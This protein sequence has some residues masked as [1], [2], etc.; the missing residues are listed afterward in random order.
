ME[1][2]RSNGDNFLVDLYKT[3]VTN[4]DPRTEQW[5]FVASPLPALA[6]MFGYFAVVW[7]GPKL[8][9][10]RKA[11]DLGHFLTVF[12]FGLVAL[13]FYITKEFLMSAILSGHWLTCQPIDYSDDPLAIRMASACW[14]YYISKYIE[15]ADTVFFILRKKGN[16]ITFL[17]VFHH[18]TMIFNWWMCVKY[19][20]GGCTV[21][22]AV[23]NSIVHVIMYTYYGLSALGPA[24]QPY[25]WWKKYVTKIQLTQFVIIL[26]HCIYVGTHCHFHLKG[27]VFLAIFYAVCM[28]TLF[29][30]Y[31]YQEYV[32]RSRLKAE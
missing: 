25:L 29:T 28:I 15:T 31:Y 22:H 17:H 16:Q 2:N 4:A 14:F 20:A 3:A 1:Q 32:R 10:N 19:I 18:G 30:N 6:A 11:I 8:M 9:E 5:L 21:F 13:S 23:I 26:G 24:V 7:V 12:N 27:F